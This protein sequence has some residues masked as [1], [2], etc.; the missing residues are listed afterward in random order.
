MTH[1]RKPPSKAS[2]GPVLLS[3][4]LNGQKKQDAARRAKLSPTQLAFFL[5][6]KRVPTLEQAARLEDCFR[7]PMR[8]WLPGWR[9]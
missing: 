5:H 4:A 1:P 9:G 6:R 7:V 3:E 2:K 8:S